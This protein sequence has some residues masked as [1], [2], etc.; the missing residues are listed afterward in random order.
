[1]TVNESQTS[2]S[3]TDAT[4]PREPRRVVQATFV[5]TMLEWY[6]FYLYGLAAAIVFAPLFFSPD[7]PVAAQL[8]ALATFTVGFLARPLGGILAG[9]FGDRLGR[10]R[11]LIVTLTIMGLATALVGLLPTYD[12]IGIWAPVL[13]VALR[14]FQGLAMGGEWGGAV[15]MAI[16]HAPANK[17][18]LYS[19]AVTVGA[20]VGMILAN[21]VLLALSLV[22]GEG[23]LTWGWRVAFLS[24][25][26]LIGVGYYA[27][28]RISESPMF[29]QAEAEATRIP[30]VEVIRN[31]GWA[32]LKMLPVAAVPGIGIYV[33]TTFLLSYGQTEVG[34]DRSLLLTI[35][36]LT[37]VVTIPVIVL[38]ARFADRISATRVAVIAGVLQIPA[39][40]VFFPLLDTG[41]FWL[42]LLGSLLAVGAYTAAA[43]V[44]PVILAR[45]F[46]TR[47]RYTGIS[48][49]YQ[50]GM[51]AGG[52]L[53]PLIAASLF[54]SARSTWVIGAYMAVGS[55]L[56]ILCTVWVH[57]SVAKQAD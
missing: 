17:K 12:Q 57:S 8:G 5:G 10:K 6:D 56:A 18:A 44:V 31:Q 26:V 28:R 3:S 15:S 45:A 33:G 27:R 49:T 41:S 34:I 23:F 55:I 1:M 13:L 24:S 46:P 54:A 52:G 2:P 42:A 11:V 25:V 35:T 14:V 21:G 43:A 4:D 29:D 53:A 48:L 32:I 36:M 22:T 30:I 7:D 16:E 9:H 50:L 20:P 40:L 51:I 47:V 19:S 39:A 38:S 37:A